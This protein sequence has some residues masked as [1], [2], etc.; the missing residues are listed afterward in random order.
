MT[1]YINT[2]TGEVKAD[3]GTLIGTVDGPPFTKPDDAIEAVKS[4]YPSDFSSLSVQDQL[5][6]IEAAGGDVEFG[7]P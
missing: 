2:E 7:T 3:D 1:I 6:T 4:Q 5:W